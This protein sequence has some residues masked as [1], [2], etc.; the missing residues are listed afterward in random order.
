M[1]YF[2]I[3]VMLLIASSNSYGQ[4]WTQYQPTIPVVE[5]PTIPTQRFFTTNVIYRPMIYQ[6]VPYIFNQ[7][8][9]I[10][11]H[12]LFCN[13]TTIEYKPTIYWVYQLSYINP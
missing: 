3:V 9:L 8:V 5:V 6:W 13:R 10:E 11:R 4:E 7:P 1:K 12:G 2:M